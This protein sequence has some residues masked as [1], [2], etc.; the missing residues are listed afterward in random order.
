MLN[1]FEELN[2]EYSNRESGSPAAAKVA[3]AIIEQA[4][5]LNLE[6]VVE[7]IKV[8]NFKNSLLAFGLGSLV[9]AFVG[10]Y[11][12]LPGFIL[13]AVLW[14][15]LLREIRR[16]VLTKIKSGEAEN[17][18]VTIPARSKEVQKV[19]LT[20]AYDTN[21]FIPT[22]LGLKPQLY[23]GLS[24]VLGF[25]APV[26]Q[27]TGI[28]L[29][30]PALLFWSLLPILLLVGLGLAA[31]TPPV[32]SGLTAC[33][34]LLETALIL[35]RFRPS[36]TTVVLYFTGGGSL[37]SAVQKL[38]ALFKGENPAYGLNLI[39]QNRPEIG[40]VNRE[41]FIPQSGSSLLKDLLVEV[42]AN[43]SIPVKCITTSEVT[44]SYPL[45]TNKMNVISLAVPTE[46]TNENL[47]ELLVGFIRQI[48]H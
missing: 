32:P 36:I 16:P 45:L 41:G 4:S 11:F 6:A 28:M 37:N 27:L 21:A 15:L 8:F 10:F 5:L 18:V 42:A 9:A 35:T 17:I 40:I 38:P 39:D 3:Q 7:K 47:R 1:T 14:L 25:T 2:R 13:Q 23:W 29:R 34:A 22:P 46:E 26:L 30:L 24:L 48:E 43:K 12:P 44:P 33:S 19:I 20:A 31:K